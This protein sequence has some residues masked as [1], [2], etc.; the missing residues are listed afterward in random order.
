MLHTSSAAKAVFVQNWPSVKSFLN[1]ER[2]FGE[3]LI[4]LPKVSMSLLLIIDKGRIDL[5]VVSESTYSSLQMVF[6][7]PHS[8]LESHPGIRWMGKIRF[9]IISLKL[10]YFLPRAM[11]R[12]GWRTGREVRYYRSLK[13]EY[14]SGPGNRKVCFPNP[15]FLASPG[16]RWQYGP[17]DRSA[18]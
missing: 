1:P 7:R 18:S 17:D 9:P 11:M 14:A 2:F 8:T 4:F 16:Q 15:C 3:A 6:C 10:R 5:I 13:G 12:F